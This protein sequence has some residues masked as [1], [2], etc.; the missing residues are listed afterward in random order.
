MTVPAE[1]N[2]DATE[3]IIPE[4]QF[5]QDV[6]IDSHEGEA[7]I[8]HLERYLVCTSFHS[9]KGDPLI[10]AVSWIS[11]WE[12]F[13]FGDIDKGFRSFAIDVAEARY[14]RKAKP[15]DIVDE[16]HQVFGPNE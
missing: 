16:L 5:S 15:V 2:I 13:R 3:P 10:T 8:T 7:G 1:H 11:M 14:H 12:I 6:L 4:G 9:F